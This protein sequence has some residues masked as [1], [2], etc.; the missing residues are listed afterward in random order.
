MPPDPPS[1][2]ALVSETKA[3]L[4]KAAA[5]MRAAECDLAAS[6]PLLEDA[7]FH[8]QQAAEKTLKSLLTW[9]SVPF[10][11]THSLEETG[12]QCLAIDPSL[13]EVIDPAVPLTE[14]AWSFRYPGEPVDPTRPETEE[15][16]SLARDLFAAILERL[17]EDARP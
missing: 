9:H 14:Y 4:V 2:P 11:R 17:P 5:D 13:G 6:P 12:E 8:C 1:D 15:A 7:C 16:L 10:R 3:W